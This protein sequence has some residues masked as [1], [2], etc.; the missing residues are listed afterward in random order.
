MIGLQCGG[1]TQSRP[2]LRAHTDLLEG[3][4][5]LAKEAT[6][7][8]LGRARS[9]RSRAAPDAAAAA[10]DIRGLG[11]AIAEPLWAEGE[12]DADQSEKKMAGPA[13]PEVVDACRVHAQGA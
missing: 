11:V 4:I 10:C 5:C 12:T 3:A 9:C 6:G 13:G 1:Y 7:R 2:S 8:E